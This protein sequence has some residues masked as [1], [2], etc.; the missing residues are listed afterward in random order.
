MMN[1][2]EYMINMYDIGS[3]NP[4]VV[5]F[6]RYPR[7]QHEHIKSTAKPKLSSAMISVKR[8]INKWIS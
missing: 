6:N 5:K 7:W 2:N 8:K 1:S 4:R 3:V